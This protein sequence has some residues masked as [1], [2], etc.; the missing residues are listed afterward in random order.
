MPHEAKQFLGNGIVKAR[1]HRHSDYHYRYA[2]GSGGNS[3][4]DDK[5]RKSAFLFCEIPPRYEK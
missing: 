3:Q 4:P 1:Y 5:G 2:E